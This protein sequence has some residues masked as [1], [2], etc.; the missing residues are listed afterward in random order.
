MV[1]EIL[2]TQLFSVPPQPQ[3]AGTRLGDNHDIGKKLVGTRVTSVKR[4]VPTAK[5]DEHGPHAHGVGYHIS[6][7]ACCAAGAQIATGSG[8]SD[9][10]D[11]EKLTEPRAGLPNIRLGL[12]SRGRG[13]SFHHSSAIR[14]GQEGAPA[15][16]RVE[17]VWESEG[18]SWSHWQSPCSLTDDSARGW[19]CS[20]AS[21]WGVQT[22]NQQSSQ[23]RWRTTNVRVAKT[24]DCGAGEVHRR[25]SPLGRGHNTTRGT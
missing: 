1:V 9:T 21:L 8:R 20:V 16:A 24:S 11:R 18:R 19:T 14:E 5:T 17:R 25:D 15:A 13:S 7:T 3:A 2:S 12:H 23:Q 22:S 4:T 6:H 10:G